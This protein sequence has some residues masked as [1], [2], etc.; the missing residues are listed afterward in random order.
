M[1]HMIRGMSLTGTV[2][3]LAPPS[4]SSLLSESSLDDE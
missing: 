4:S 2:P 1:A 3:S